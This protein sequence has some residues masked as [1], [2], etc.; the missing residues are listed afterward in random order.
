MLALDLVRAE[1]KAV[2]EAP[3]SEAELQTAKQA[4]VNGFVFNF[5]D[6]SQT[7][8]RAAYYEAIGYPAD[9]LQRYQKSLAEVTSAS[10]LAAA[11]RK[12][13]PEEQVVIIV[14]KESDFDR[15]LASAGLPVERVDLTIPPPPSKR[16]GGA[17]ASASPEARKRGAEWLAAAAK[18]AGGSAAWAAV[19]TVTVATDATVSMQGQS[20]S[21][22]GEETWALP[23]RQV[24]VQKL[25]FGE[26]RRGYDG[27]SGWMS[28]MGQLRDDPK[29]GEEYAKD[30]GH[31]MWRLFSDPS[32][33]ELVALDA[34]EKVGDR[35]FKAAMVVGAKA[36]DLVLL[37]GED[38]RLAGFAYQDE[39]S[40]QMEPARVVEL[41]DDWSAEGALQYPHTV[42][43]TR[44][45]AAFVDGKVTGLKVNPAVA[46]DAFRKPAK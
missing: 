1:V 12:I 7:L 24:S 29:A 43:V 27:K 22:S 30:W 6:P 3:F 2:T 20:I 25:P 33:V 14:G 4:V 41:Y 32:K 39:G 28:G 19:K 38:G 42:K 44:N 31:S 5:E 11:K 37:F 35:E 13:T 15:P 17:A 10:V 16:A 40:G 45:G 9:F 8:F 21:V 23:D 18:A 36:Q 46:A 34:P 26:I